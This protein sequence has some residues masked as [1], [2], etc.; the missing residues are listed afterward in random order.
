MSRFNTQVHRAGTVYIAA[1]GSAEAVVPIEGG[2]LCAHRKLL[3]TGKSDVYAIRC[4]R[5]GHRWCNKTIDRRLF[6]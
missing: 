4:A 3:L 6:P 1:G 5:C 2:T